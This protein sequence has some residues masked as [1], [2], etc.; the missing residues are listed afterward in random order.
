MSFI[1]DSVRDDLRGAERSLPEGEET[2][3]DAN[4]EGIQV[5]RQAFLALQ[6]RTSKKV[7]M[8]ESETKKG[9]FRCPLS[10]IAYKIVIT[11]KWG[12]MT[13]DQTYLWHLF[14]FHRGL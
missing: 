5:I 10:W 3:V 7:M 4:W 2:L 14:M 6:I 11:L 1:V 13:V 9:A 12:F 8:K